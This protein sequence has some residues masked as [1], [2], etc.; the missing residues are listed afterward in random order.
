VRVWPPTELIS[1]KTKIPSFSR[2]LL[3]NVAVLISLC[4]VA[5][6]ADTAALSFTSGVGSG[7]NQLHSV[8]AGW[9]FT[10]SSPVLVTQLGLWDGAGPAQGGSLGDGFGVAHNVTLWTAAGTAL[11]TASIPSGTT[12]TLGADDFRYVT[13]GSAVALAPG[14]YVITAYYAQ[15]SF[16][17]DFANAGTITTAAGVTYG[18]AGDLAGAIPMPAPFHGSRQVFDLTGTAFPTGD[19][20]SA[21]KSFFGPNFQFEAVPEVSSLSLLLVGAGV[22]SGLRLIA[23][24]RQA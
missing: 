7:T 16:D 3:L 1:M 23:R 11:T 21:P 19:S 18:T 17:V 13:L 15:S 14:D 5:T 22:L 9:S 20:T 24:R 6:R 8:V 4:P 12:A 2:T 10:L